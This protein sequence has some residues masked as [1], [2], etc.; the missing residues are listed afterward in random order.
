LVNAHLTGP[1]EWFLVPLFVVN[2]VVERIKDGTIPVGRRIYFI[3]RHRGRTWRS[4]ENYFAISPFARADGSLLLANCR[5]PANEGL[6][7]LAP[8]LDASQR[9]QNHVGC[10]QTRLKPP[11]SGE[12]A[13]V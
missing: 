9:L 3:L 7:E 10:D 2:E 6:G 8:Q 11:E 13:R 4:T 1:R 5:C 12:D